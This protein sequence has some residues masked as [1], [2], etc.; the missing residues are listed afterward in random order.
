[1]LRI[2]LRDVKGPFAGYLSSSMTGIMPSTP[3]RS[4]I[5]VGKEGERNAD[6]PYSVGSDFYDTSARVASEQDRVL[7]V[8]VTVP[9]A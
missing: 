5:G 3:L 4:V 9:L 6:F 8:S 7:S 1:M 2:A